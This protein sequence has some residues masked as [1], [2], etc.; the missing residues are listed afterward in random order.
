MAER[1]GNLPQDQH[2]DELS[3]SVLDTDSL[4]HG[5]TGHAGDRHK[6]ADRFQAVL[7]IEIQVTPNAINKAQDMRAEGYPIIFPYAH[8]AMRDPIDAIGT[9]INL[10][11]GFDEPRFSGPVAYHHWQKPYIRKFAE[12]AHM[13]ASPIVTAST[14]AKGKNYES[15]PLATQVKYGMRETLGHI[16]G[17]PAYD[18]PE[19]RKIPSRKGLDESLT[20]DIR[21]LKERGL[22]FTAPQGERLPM[23]GESSGPVIEALSRRVDK[24]GIDPDKVGVWPMGI[25]IMDDDK[26]E[27]H[28]TNH[29]L[30]HTIRKEAVVKLETP[31]TLRALR[32]M[33]QEAIAAGDV[34][35]TV[36]SSTFK[37]LRR[38]LP[39]SYYEE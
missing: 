38:V 25:M 16:P 10:G 12:L 1:E 33:T 4:Q 18:R 19:P 14:I 7:P 32:E 23:L 26:P 35:A 6:W 20:S 30:V 27:E 3:F 17:I 11:R 24:A 28:D 5:S 13:D 29:G 22:V 36:D 15:I 2:V 34:K 9:A 21:T 39:H 37:L 31:I 8:S